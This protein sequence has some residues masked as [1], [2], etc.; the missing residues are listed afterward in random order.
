MDVLTRLHGRACQVTEEI[1]CLISSGLADGAMA[2][3]RTLHEIA[4]TAF[5][6]KD[7]GEKLA[8]RYID[9]EHIESFKAARDYQ[10]CCKRL[11]CEPI[12]NEEFDNLELGYNKLLKKYGSDFKNQYGWASE[13]LGKRRPSIR[14]IEL[15]AGIDH[16]RAYYRMASHNVHANPKGVFFKLGLF[17][18]DQII[19]TGASNVGLVEPGHS[20]AVSLLHVSTAI[21]TI[22]PTLDSLVFLKMLARLE[23]EIGES[24]LKANQ[25]LDDE[26]MSADR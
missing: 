25:K 23:N 1:I 6:I 13:V 22:K 9:H 24:F 7:Q 18:E 3:W 5:L 15:A 2:R 14:D 20:A 19:L 21:G 10:D 16:L 17:D 4:I 11:D 12:A 8:K 26:I